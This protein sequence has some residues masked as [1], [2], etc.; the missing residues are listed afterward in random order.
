MEESSQALK[1]IIANDEGND[2]LNEKRQAVG[3]ALK[4]WMYFLP[5]VLFIVF[6]I[7]WRLPLL[8]N[9][10][11]ESLYFDIRIVGLI[12][13]IN[14]LMNPLLGIPD[15]ILV[16]ANIGYKST[17]IKTSGVVVTNVLMVVSSFLGYGVIGLAYVVLFST[18]VNGIFVYFVCKKNIPWLGVQKP[19]KEQV[20]K[21][22]GFSFW[23]LIW[24]FIAKLI[25][26][27]EILVIGY[28]ISPEMVSDYVFSS[29]IMQLAVSLALIT[30]SAVTPGLGKLIGSQNLRKAREVVENT[31]EIIRFLSVFFGAFILLINKNFV[32]L[33]MGE[34][35]FMG[36]YVN[37]LIVLTM[38]QLVA[39]RNEGQIQ[40]LSLDIK[41]K[42]LI[43]GVFSVISIILA[44]VFYYLM[45]ESMEG[46]FIGILIGRLFLNFVFR[47]MVD[48]M[49]DMKSDFRSF[50]VVMIV[51]VLSFY[52]GTLIPVTD[53][54]IVFLIST[55]VIA[56]VLLLI[57][58]KIFLSIENQ[59]KVL[60]LL[61]RKL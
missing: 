29:Y 28:L 55:S 47:K 40:D 59:K 34:V 22:F 53:S 50:I 24:S 26:A 49:M 23:V 20:Q 38:I 46:I 14:L 31:R 8:I 41:K 39:F 51:I 13:G 43:G 42:V 1:W 44:F 15:S 33:W 10:L 21:F 2:N 36:D 5:F 37:L 18:L 3:S 11:N 45:G 17:M 7:V 32:S 6:L 35:H 48:R 25:L 9:G 58:Y 54:W 12:L 4:I 60:Q 52:L 16:G 61:D 27:T 30:G 56:L 57:C 19:T